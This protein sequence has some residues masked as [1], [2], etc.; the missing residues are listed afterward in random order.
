MP[1]E[2]NML[3]RNAKNLMLVIKGLVEEGI[4]FKVKKESHDYHFEKDVIWILSIENE[5]IEEEV[6][7]DEF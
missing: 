4:T 3:F 6:N 7:D 5:W 1:K 2:N